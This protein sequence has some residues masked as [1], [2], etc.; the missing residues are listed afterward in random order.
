MAAAQGQGQGQAQGQDS[1]AI[2][3]GTG[4]HGQPVQN[5]QIKSLQFSEPSKAVFVEDEKG[6]PS[7]QYNQ[8]Q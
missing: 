1:G 3:S 2:P 7:L 5:R 8:K 4:D 6:R